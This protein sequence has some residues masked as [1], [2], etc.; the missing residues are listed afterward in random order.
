MNKTVIISVILVIVAIGLGFFGGIEYQLH[1]AGS[2]RFGGGS[3]PGAGGGRFRQ[4]FG[5]GG[6]A[7]QN[8][9]PIR[10]QVLSADANTLT[11]KMSDGST[12]IIV[13]SGSTVFQKTSTA[14]ATDIKQGS[15]VV[16]VG[17]QD[18][19]GSVTA[20]SVSIN[21]VGMRGPTTPQEK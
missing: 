13:L 7:G 11:V 4:A 19:S 15:T 20:Q 18:S 1:K 17:Q 9:V 16:V 6:G 8:F 2:S 5:G 21:P 12:K 10:G 14:S 3:F